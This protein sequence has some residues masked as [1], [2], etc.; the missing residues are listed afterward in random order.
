MRSKFSRKRSKLHEDFEENELV[1]AKV[2]GYSHWPAKV[3]KKW[4][5]KSE[6]YMYQV[7]FYGT[8]EM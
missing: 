2:K 8:Y 6:N 7:V 5:K 3:I 1:F 4:K